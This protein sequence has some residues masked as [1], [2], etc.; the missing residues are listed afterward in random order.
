MGSARLRQ[1]ISGR[2]L[3]LVE[4]TVYVRHLT[5]EAAEKDAHRLR[6]GG[7][8][9]DVKADGDRWLVRAHRDDGLDDA[10]TIERI[11]AFRP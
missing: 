7:F 9:A 1:R 8:E 11:E 2:I 6:R 10:Y 4:R 5:I 3:Q